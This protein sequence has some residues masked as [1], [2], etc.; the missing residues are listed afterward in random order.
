MKSLA[1][2]P[3]EF[4]CYITCKGERKGPFTLTQLKQMR[5]EEMLP[6]DAFTPEEWTALRDLLDAQEVNET[7]FWK[8]NPLVEIKRIAGKKKKA[9]SGLHA[10]L[11]CLTWIGY[12]IGGFF[13][14]WGILQAEKGPF[15]HSPSLLIAMFFAMRLARTSVEKMVRRRLPTQDKI[16]S[17]KL[18]FAAYF[19][20]LLPFSLLIGCALAV[21]ARSVTKEA[22]QPMI[23]AAVLCW[24]AGIFF[25][26]RLPSSLFFQWRTLSLKAARPYAPDWMILPILVFTFI[27]LD[28]YANEFPRVKVIT[29]YA[30]LMVFNLEPEVQIP[31]WH[32]PVGLG[33]SRR[34]VEKNFGQADRVREAQ[35]WFEEPSVAI[36]YNFFNYVTKLRF[37]NPGTARRKL[38]AFL[39]DLTAA[40]TMDQLTARLNAPNAIFVGKNFQ[41][42]I[43]NKPPL[44][45]AATAWTQSV[46]NNG[47]TFAKG[48]LKWLEVTHSEKDLAP[49]RAGLD[50]NRK[51]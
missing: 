3:E 7:G 13:L 39:W 12:G 32:F 4:S 25:S 18:L 30:R 16:P 33:S 51:E 8:K 22:L 20:G 15:Y 35:F 21:A 45:L 43:W 17:K 24:G 27:V 1:N 19:L 11:I 6:E 36:T 28:H 44:R 37:V 50:S 10:L 2:Q 26:M 46:T 29:N 38:P 14:V 47:N 48:S 41:T 31:D 9:R 42:C 34:K 40:S 49:T 5:A 23:N